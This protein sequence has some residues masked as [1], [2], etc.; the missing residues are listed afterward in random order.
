MHKWCDTY[1]VCTTHR[2]YAYVTSRIWAS[3]VT[4]AKALQNKLWKHDAVYRPL[5]VKMSQCTS[6]TGLTSRETDG[7]AALFFCT[8]TGKPA[9]PGAYCDMYQWVMSHV[10]MSHVTRINESWDICKR[11]LKQTAAR[12][13]ASLGACSGAYSPGLDCSTRQWFACDMTHS[14]ETW[15]VYMRHGPLI[16]D[17][18][19]WLVAWPWMLARSWFGCMRHDSLVRDMTH[20]YGTCL[21]HMGRASFIWDVPY[22]WETW[23]IDICDMTSW[24]IYTEMIHSYGIYALFIRDMTHLHVWPDSFIVWHD[25]FIRV[26]WLIHLCDMTH[27]HE[28]HDSFIC[29]IP[30]IH[31]C[32]MI[33]SHVWYD[34]FTCVIWLIAIRGVTHSQVQYALFTSTI[35]PIHKCDIAQYWPMGTHIYINTNTHIHTQTLVRLCMKTTW[36]IPIS[37]V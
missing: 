2:W 18:M 31:M 8:A 17:V 26:T 5:K 25:S 34:S 3:H 6:S 33:H 23:L 15:L 16:R 30:L 1:I 19:T 14:Y 7:A 37:H 36:L 10:S 9:S 27:S 35:W 32:D 13:P 28:R 24:P 12:Q 29:V 20:S 4:H 22:S 11:D 21:I